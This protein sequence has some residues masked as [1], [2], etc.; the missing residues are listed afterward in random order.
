MKRSLYTYLFRNR[1]SFYLYNSQTGFFSEINETLF[2]A[3]FNEDIKSFDPKFIKHLK[4]KKIIVEDG[5]LYDYYH[6]SRLNHLYSMG[7]NDILGL[8]IAPTTGCNF[9]CPYCFE[10]NKKDKRMTS[11]TISDIINF[12]NSSNRY[13]ELHITW[14]GGEPLTAFDIIKSIVLRIRSECQIPITSQSIVTNGY[15][16]NQD[17][18][19]FLKDNQFKNIQITFDGAETNHNKTRGLKGNHMPTF[20]KIMTNLDRIVTELP[21]N[22]RISI[23]VNVNKKNEQDFAL[24][25]NLIKE[26]YPQKRNLVVYPGFIRESNTTDMYMCF[27]SLVGKSRYEFYKKIQNHGIN[28]DFYPQIYNKGCMACQNSSFIIGPS[29]ELYKCWNDFNHP[30]KIVGYIKDRK[31]TNPSLISQ[32]ACDSN[33]FYDVKCKDCKIFPVCNG[34]CTWYRNKNIYEGK[35]YDVCSFLVDDTI[36]EECLLAKPIEKGEKVIKAF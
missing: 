32:Y 8:T 25:Y 31:I 12:I 7:N 13:K 34:G 22:T 15:L 21:E 2:E 3:L 30:E 28:V 6:L 1:D 24:L 14:Y 27:N 4:D 23:R 5:H 29:G 10:G 17:V 11:E 18:I 20:H 9:A 33:V 19:A 26:K 16:L 36:L 35:R